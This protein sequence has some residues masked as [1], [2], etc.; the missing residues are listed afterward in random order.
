M[1]HR[2]KAGEQSAMMMASGRRKS[3]SPAA[4]SGRSRTV[5]DYRTDL[6]RMADALRG[7]MDAAEYKHFVLGLV[8]LKYISDAFKEAYAKLE[9]EREYDA[10][11]EDPDEY[12]AQ[13]IFWVP[14]EARWLHLRNQARQSTIGRPVDKAMTAVERDNPG[15]KDVLP[16]EYGR[17]AFDKQCL[18]QV[19]DLVSNIRVGGASAEAT[20]V[21]GQVYEY[22]L[23]QFALA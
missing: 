4:N 18:G 12:R 16:K 11:P 13:S 21:L 23:E 1:G 2:R 19:V 6:W 17:D 14:T 7:S 22:F 3:S 8:F 5:A 10:D 9:A 15:L 20:D